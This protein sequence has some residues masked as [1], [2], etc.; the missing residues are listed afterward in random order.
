VRVWAAKT[1]IAPKAIWS[2][3]NIRIERRRI[4][5]TLAVA[6]LWLGAS[7]GLA[8]T[9]D[10]PNVP[11]SQ[12]MR[13]WRRLQLSIP[14]PVAGVEMNTTVFVP[15]GKGPFPLAVVNHGST[16]SEELRADYA[17]PVFEALSSW[18]LTRGYLVVLPQR[19]GHG[20]TGGSYIETA[21]DCADAR[22][23]AA[24]IATAKSIEAA[25]E[26][27]LH[28]SYVRKTPAL[29]L[30]HS[31][32][33]WGALAL[34]SMRPDLVRGVVNFSGGRG[35][36]SY[37]VAYRNCAPERLVAAAR[38]F[39]RT[40]RAPSLWIYSANDSYF[41]PDLSRRMADAF[42]A[43]GAFVDYQLLPPMPEEGHLLVYS[44][45]SIGYW[46]PALERFLRTLR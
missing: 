26:Y 16:E 39:G 28:Q 10:E 44:P 31:A 21:G 42:G 1:P 2:R 25:V 23:E 5:G 29:L 20:K 41:P 14:S 45:R 11:F 43:A 40:A 4:L 18:L 32:G 35:G 46:A 6:L 24:G 15:R 36:R 9:A 17:A 3:M 27:M 19:P 38:E 7:L 12:S 13:Q 22:Y 34:A 33:G 8:Q 30:G 37:D